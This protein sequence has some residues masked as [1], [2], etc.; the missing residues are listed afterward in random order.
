MKTIT[1]SFLMVF[2][3]A[4]CDKKDDK[5]TILSENTFISQRANQAWSGTT[6]LSLT[7]DDTL[8]FLGNGTGL[9]NGIIVIKVKFEG[10]GSNIL[11]N[12]QG[13]YYNTLGE[14]VV[15][16]QFSIHPKKQGEFLISE[17]DEGL[18]LVKGTFELPL[19]AT[20]LN[21]TISTDSTLTI[22]NG[23]FKGK[24]RDGIAQ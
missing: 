21:G 15:V 13:I 1:L 6:E 24:I 19:K 23:H 17:Y 14:D 12:K 18:G 3:L 20:L 8:V 11:E 22:A 9:D 5:G 16:S 7:A 10:E 2:L 4:T